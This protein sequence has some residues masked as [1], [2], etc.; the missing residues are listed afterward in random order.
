MKGVKGMIES[1]KTDGETLIRKNDPWLMFFATL[2]GMTGLKWDTTEGD[3][4]VDQIQNDIYHLYAT[5]AWKLL[6]TQS[7]TDLANRI[8]KLLVLPRMDTHLEK[9]VSRV[10]DGF[11]AHELAAYGDTLSE[12]LSTKI[13]SAFEEQI[14]VKVRRAVDAAVEAALQDLK[15]RIATK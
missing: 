7:K 9:A 3:A 14:D 8:A 12:K 2:L 6:S 1:I 13:L 10:V 11:I 15:T 4:V 5:E